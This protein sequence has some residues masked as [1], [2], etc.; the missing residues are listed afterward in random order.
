MTDVPAGTMETLCI[1][2]IRL[3]TQCW[4]RGDSKIQSS[5]LVCLYQE[6]GSVTWI[7]ICHSRWLIAQV[8]GRRLEFWDLENL[9]DSPAAVEDGI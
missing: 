8:N 3:G 6:G 9:A 5:P 4:D 7:N 2:A 1:R